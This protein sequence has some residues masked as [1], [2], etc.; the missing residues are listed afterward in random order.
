MS[1][2]FGAGNILIAE[3]ADLVNAEDGRIKERQDCL[4]LEVGKGLDKIPDFFLRRKI[5][6][7]GGKSAYRELSGSQ[8]LCRMSER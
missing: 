8:G 7:A 6:P 2:H 5:G 4:V 1:P 3:G